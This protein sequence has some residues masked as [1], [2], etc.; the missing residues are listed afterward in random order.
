ML[1]GYRT[2]IASALTAAL[3]VLA[4]VDWNTVLQNPKSSAGLVAIGSGVLMAILR[5]ITTTPP[6]SKN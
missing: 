6:L 5:T 4:A 2:Y 3:G 1:T